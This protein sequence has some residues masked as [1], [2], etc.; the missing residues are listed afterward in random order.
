MRATL[1][2]LA[3]F[4]SF[5]AAAQTKVKPEPLYNITIFKWAK[6]VTGE[7]YEVVLN[8]FEGDTARIEKR[9][10]EGDDLSFTQKVNISDFEKGVFKF[11][12]EE[13]IARKPAY[14]SE[15]MGNAQ[16]PEEGQQVLHITIVTTKDFKNQGSNEYPAEYFKIVV[17]DFDDP[18]PKAFF[19]YFS[20]KEAETLQRLLSN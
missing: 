3:F 15:E 14:S 1:F 5:I 18:N 11:I 19:K 7:E 2:I 13:K 20:K 6:D 4:C 16:I 12:S 10:T 8:I 17:S 9:I